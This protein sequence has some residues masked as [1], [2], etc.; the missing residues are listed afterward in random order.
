MQCHSSFV[1]TDPKGSVVCEV[2]KLLEKKDY[3]IKIFN[4]ISFKKSMHYNPFAYI[5]SE[6]DILKLVTTLITN[7][8]GDGKSGDEFWTSATRSQAVKSL[9]TGNGFPLFGELIV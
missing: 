6:K 4:T 3:R 2:G 5:H 9:R 7:T 1:V 8:E